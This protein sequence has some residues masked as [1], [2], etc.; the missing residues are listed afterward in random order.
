M[1]KKS[2]KAALKSSKCDD[3]VLLTPQEIESKLVGKLGELERKLRV[4]IT[5][6]KLTGHD[7]RYL[8]KFGPPPGHWLEMY[9]YYYPPCGRFYVEHISPVVQSIVDAIENNDSSF[10]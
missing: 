7:D 5:Y 4:P 2:K 10:L 6:N 1:S 9:I 3:L 8:V